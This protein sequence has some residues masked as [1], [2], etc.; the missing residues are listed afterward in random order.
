M[1]A[2]A[3]VDVVDFTVEL[4]DEVVCAV[5]DV[6]DEAGLV[7]EPDPPPLLAPAYNIHRMEFRKSLIMDQRQDTYSTGV[8][9]RSR[10]GVSR[11]GAVVQQLF[12]SEC[13]TLN[14][15]RTWSGQR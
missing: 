4:E 13:Q 6:E 11:P 12:N 14:V 10:D 8:E 5:L 9:R 15:K 7:V 3:E 1:E 2:G